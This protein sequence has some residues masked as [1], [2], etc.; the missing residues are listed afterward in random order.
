MF[1]VYANFLSPHSSLWSGV[2]LSPENHKSEGFI[3]SQSLCPVTV[4]TSLMKT[5]SGQT[6]YSIVLI[7]TYRTKSLR[8]LDGKFSHS[9]W[10]CYSAALPLQ[11]SDFLHAD[12]LHWVSESYRLMEITAASL[13]LRFCSTFWC[14]GTGLCS[15]DTILLCWFTF[16]SGYSLWNQRT[17]DCKNDCYLLD[18]DRFCTKI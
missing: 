2:S 7:G 10:C 8:A 12:C 11:E 16:S 17:W 4:H 3:E 18:L 13:D 5:M 9:S 1:Q 6:V 14:S 15:L